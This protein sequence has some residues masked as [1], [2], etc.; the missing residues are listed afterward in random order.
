[1]SRADDPP[2]PSAA[3]TTTSDQPLADQ[4]R[5]LQER[6]DQMSKALTPPTMP[7]EEKPRKS[8]SDEDHPKPAKD[9][10][11]P[12]GPPPLTLK[13]VTLYGAIDVSIAH[14]THGAPLSNTYPA[15]LPF[16]LQAFSNRPITSI[17]NN[18]LSQSRI[19]L[20]GAEPLG[21]L[22]IKAVFRLETGF[23]PTS[24]R[25]SDGPQSLIDDNG[26]ANAKKIT[27]GDSGRAGQ[28]FNSAA[29]VGLSSATYGTLTFGRQNSL[30]ADDLLK[31]D[32]QLQSQSFSPISYSGTSGGFGDTEDKTLD[33]S[34]K[35]V[36]GYGP[37]HAMGQYQFGHTNYEPEGA[38]GVDVGA[39]IA[40]LS[41]DAVFG[42]VKGAIAAT[43]LSAAQVAAGNP[44]NTLAAT[45]S[46]NTGYS[47][48]ALYKINPVK[49]FA[50]YEHI[51][52]ANP[53]KPMPNGTVTIGS[54][55]LSAINNAAYNIER[56]LDYFWGGIRYSVL[57]ELELSAAYYLFL[58]NSYNANGCKDDSAGSCS[59]TF[60]DVSFVADYRLTRRFDVY[61]GFNYTTGSDG[62]AAGFLNTSNLATAAGIRFTF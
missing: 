15:S 31:Y 54:Y 41:V 8:E 57:P 26:V 61:A 42:K 44:L 49:I 20:S 56:K 1:M 50:A 5:A 14:L 55:V 16:V 25:L 28:V 39:E 19:G 58:Q 35:Y 36:I 33:S 11:P 43:S 3:P 23:Q 62:L 4:V 30:M 9:A 29:Y 48:M 51:T 22:D 6:V 32:P 53:D 40:G 34:V 10:P 12:S 17:A 46:D 38:Y 47:V 7:P 27:S 37:V 60:H 59:G 2:A 13:G 24:G 52:Y 45:V 18:G 21:L